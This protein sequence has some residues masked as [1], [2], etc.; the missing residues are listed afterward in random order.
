MYNSRPNNTFNNL[1]KEL[2]A[3]YYAP[4]YKQIYRDL[5]NY[6]LKYFPHKSLETP[7]SEVTVFN[8]DLYYLLDEMMR[9]MELNKGLGLAANQIGGTVSALLVKDNKEVIYEMINPVLI[10]ANGAIVLR[11][12]CLSAPGVFVPIQRAESV[13]VQ[14]QDRHGEAKNL[15]AEGM[16]AR[17]VLHEMEHL[18]GKGFL[19]NTNRATRKAS[20][21]KIKKYSK[22]NVA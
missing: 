20:L 6:S 10:E 5:M 3:D 14:Y 7:T 18:S 11:E 16:L 22:N 8:N 9:I 21:S 17:A 4:N 19:D 13:L 12:G 2:Y 15:M 1:F